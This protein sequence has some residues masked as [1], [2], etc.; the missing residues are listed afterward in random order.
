MEPSAAALSAGGH[1]PFY[2]AG[3]RPALFAGALAANVD[4]SRIR[5]VVANVGE[6]LD[7][8]LGALS[9]LEV[10]VSAGA[11]VAWEREQQPRRECSGWYARRR[12]RWRSH[13]ARWRRPSPCGLI[14]SCC[15]EASQMR[16]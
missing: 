11:A 4:R 9:A 13:T 12:S 1:S 8:R 6:Q 14:S 10:T 7:F 3:M 15:T 16:R 5:R 2:V